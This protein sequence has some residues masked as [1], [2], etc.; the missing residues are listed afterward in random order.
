M[1]L[2]R[3]FVTGS[4]ESERNDVP[5]ES[6]FLILSSVKWGALHSETLL[7]PFKTVNL[8]R[9][10]FR[11]S[12]FTNTGLYLYLLFNVLKLGESH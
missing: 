11:T 8:K 6:T 12:R 10:A 1:P 9:S 2:F 3:Y 7:E 5:G 4:D